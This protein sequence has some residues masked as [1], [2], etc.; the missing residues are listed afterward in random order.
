MT[1]WIDE[2]AKWG[3]H[4]AYTLP[5]KVM[6]PS[7]TVKAG[8]ALDNTS[9]FLKNSIDNFVLSRLESEQLEPNSPA[10]KNIIS[11]RLAF[12]LTGLPPEKRIL[13]LFESGQI[14]YENMVDTLLSQNTFGEKWA[15]WWL[16]MARYSDTKGYEKDLGR[17]IHQYRDWAIKAFNS[18]MP[19]DQFTIEQLAGGLLPEPSVDQ[20]IATAFHRNTMNNDEGSTDDEEFRVATVID[21]VNT[22]FEVWQSTTIGC[23]Q[24]H[25]HPY[26]SFKHEEY[27]NVMAFFNN[28]RDEDIPSEAPVLKFYSPQ[29]QLLVDKVNDWV[30]QYGGKETAESYSNF[31]RFTEP[32]Y[33][34][35]LLQDFK[36][37]TYDDHASAVLW[38][39]GSCIL[40]NVHTQKAGFMYIKSASH[41]DGT[42]MT[43]RKDNSQG[44]LLA[45][46]TVNKSKSS[47]ITRFPFKKIDGSIYILKS[48]TPIFLKKPMPSIYI[49][50][51]L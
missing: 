22:T 28:S 43:L 48:I 2:G 31:L 47:H 41:F 27:Y 34:A 37:G 6:V 10:N 36:N 49:G 1:R 11:R 42:T 3:E 51:H 12:D 5:E 14:S 45:R 20:L 9:D 8:F 25:S 38:N 18:D 16:D 39:D 21:R 32:V 19:Y 29:Q 7:V 35:H 30:S 46:F 15:S 40:K 50:W 44:E 26:D 4:W 13:D 23:V 33:N 24:C 17:N